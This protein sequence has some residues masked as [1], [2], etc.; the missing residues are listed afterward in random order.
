MSYGLM[1]YILDEMVD[2]NMNLNKDSNLKD[3]K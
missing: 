2:L 1:K 3:E